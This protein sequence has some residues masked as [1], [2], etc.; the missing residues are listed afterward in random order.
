MRVVEAGVV[1]ASEASG[2]RPGSATWRMTGG[3]EAAS[4]AV[5]EGQGGG[6]SCSGVWT[7]EPGLG[8]GRIGRYS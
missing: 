5:A 8:P 4:V 7:E 6:G 3:G 2:S 1:L